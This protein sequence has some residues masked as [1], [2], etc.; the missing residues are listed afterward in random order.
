M[1]DSRPP[2]ERDESGYLKS[3]EA[4]F[5]VVSELLGDKVSWAEFLHQGKTEGIN[6]PPFITEKI[7]KMGTDGNRNLIT[8]DLGSVID[9]QHRQI[10][11]S[12]KSNQ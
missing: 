12:R 1:I 9:K 4:C 11:D 2:Y 5:N 6:L 8:R 10:L 7:H 3:T